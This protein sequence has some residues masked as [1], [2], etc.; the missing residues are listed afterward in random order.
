MK[1]YKPLIIGLCLI[2]IIT[3]LISKIYYWF[4]L[5]SMSSMQVLM[6]VWFLIFGLMKLPDIPWFA[7]IFSQYDP[8][9]QLLPIYGY[10]YPVFEVILGIW[11]LYD[12]SMRYS[13][14]MNSIAMIITAITTVGILIKLISKS[15][16]QCACMWSKIAIP[17]WRPSLIEQWAMSIMAWRM[18]LM[19]I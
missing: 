19:M 8:L 9:A 5:Q 11:Y 1:T 14:P 15:Q 4:E 16:I 10:M 6:W 13:L 12:I 17:L 7:N 18:I 3:F 2:W